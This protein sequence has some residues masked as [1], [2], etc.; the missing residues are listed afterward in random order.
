MR[1]IY[2][3][4]FTI[5]I[6]S[7]TLWGQQNPQQQLY[8]SFL[9]E[10]HGQFDKALQDLLLLTRSNV[11]SHAECGRAWTLLGFAYQEQGQF[12]QARNAYKQSLHILKGDTVDIADYAN[13]LDYFARFYRDISQQQMATTL[14]LK[15]VRIDEQRGDHRGTARIYTGLAGLAIE[16][17]HVREAKEFLDKAVAES[18][19]TKEITE[20]DIA[21]LSVAQA[22]IA[23][24]EG[25]K[26]VAIASYANALK[27]WKQQHGELH[28]LAG[29]GYLLLGKAFASNGQLQDALANMRQGLTILNQTTGPQNPKYLAGEIAYATVL[30]QT[31]MH[32]EG[33]Q[34]KS[35]AERSLATLV[36]DQCM[37]CTVNVAALR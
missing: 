2:V 28:P 35:T 14:W 26:T 5:G 11:L 22:R 12:Q 16:G 10:Q 18:K 36:G 33:S 21:D 9:L 1:R 27:S 7:S 23:G 19:I 34:L 29:W 15:A 25:N 24:A 17:G 32:T 30:E 6:L 13:A 37:D 31:G 8:K 3:L 20:D 4:I